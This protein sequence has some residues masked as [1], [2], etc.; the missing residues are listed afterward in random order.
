MTALTEATAW[1]EE[2]LGTKLAVCQYIEHRKIS[3]DPEGRLIWRPRHGPFV[4]LESLVLGRTTYTTPSVTLV[5]ERTVIVDLQST[6]AAWTGALRFGS[7]GETDSTWQYLAGYSEVPP[8][9]RDAIA[10]RAQS[11]LDGSDSAD[12]ALLLDSYRWTR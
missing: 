10:L 7:P 8:E 9:I 1:C 6:T 4:L 12:A 2:Y 11:V 3:P 5:D